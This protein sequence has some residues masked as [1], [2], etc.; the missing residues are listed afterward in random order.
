L[1]NWMRQTSR[2]SCVASMNVRNV[3]VRH[4]RRSAVRR[5][6]LRYTSAEIPSPLPGA[7][8]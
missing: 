1:L 3:R 4:D 2:D 8:E 6:W 7:L 5:E